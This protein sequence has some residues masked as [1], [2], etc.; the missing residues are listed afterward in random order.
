VQAQPAQ[1]Q[2]EQTP[3]ALPRTASN[4]PGIGLAGL[5]AVLLG[6]GLPRLRRQMR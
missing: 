2:T 4:L 1:P 5:I 3:N 6:L